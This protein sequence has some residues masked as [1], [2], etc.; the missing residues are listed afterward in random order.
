MKGF[1]DSTLVIGSQFGDEGKGKLVDCLAEKSDCVVRFQGGNNAGHTVVVDGKEFKLHLLPSGT[2]RKKRSLI[3]TGVSLDPRVLKQE[4][5]SLKEKKIEVNLGIDPRCQIIMPWHNVIDIGKEEALKEK[6]IGTTRRGVGPCYADRASRIGIRFDDLV[7][8]KRLSEKINF[9]Y[10]YYKNVCEKVLGKEF[11]FTEE[12]VFQQYSALGKEFKKHLTDVSIEVND[13]LVKGKKVL[14]EGA[15]GTMLDNDFGTYPFVTSS[16]PISGAATIGIG[17]SPQKLKRI[18]A[19]VKAYTTRVGSGPFP[20]EL[21]ETEADFLRNA[22]NEF[23]TT[24]GRA[25]RVGWLDLPMLRMANRL[26]G[27]TELAITKLDVLS[28]IKKLLIAESYS[29][30]GKKILEFPYANHLI[31]K[32]KPNYIEFKGFVLE[33]KDRKELREEGYSVLDPKAKKYLGFIEKQLKVPIKTISFG[34]D[35]IDTLTKGK[36]VC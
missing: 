21:N 5:D 3:G 22:G 2:I 9:N 25:R 31:E 19:V 28:G 11:D 33:E 29:I 16:H 12:E 17:L 35:R 1:M 27:F 34:P 14:F 20:T 24:T 15:Q 10:S 7:D 4:I 36:S 8:E 18:I 6:N 30:E 26:N 23:G 32:A 13:F